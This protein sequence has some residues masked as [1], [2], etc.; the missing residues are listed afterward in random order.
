MDT[1]CTM[2]KSLHLN[3]WCLKDRS[4]SS[5][6]ELVLLFIAKRSLIVTCWVRLEHLVRNAVRT[7]RCTGRWTRIVLSVSIRLD[8]GRV[9][10]WS[11]RVTYAENLARLTGSSPSAVGS[12]LHFPNLSFCLCFYDQLKLFFLRNGGYRPWTLHGWANYDGLNLYVIFGL[13]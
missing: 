3:L 1:C 8:K 5:I 7:I 12:N 11:K 10:V 4:H 2:R 9:E 13:N 6:H